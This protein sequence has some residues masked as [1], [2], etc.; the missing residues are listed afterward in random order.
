[1]IRNSTVPKW[2]R[3][4]GLG[5]DKKWTADDN[6]L[7]AKVASAIVYGDLSTA[8]LDALKMKLHAQ[9]IAP[10]VKHLNGVTTLYVVPVNYM[11]GFPV[12][13][14]TP[15]F[16]T[17][18]VPSGSFSARLKERTSPTGQRLLALGDPIYENSKL[19]TRGA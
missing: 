8:D 14:L 19:P 11:S 3:L 12:D 5:P 18:Y 7:P 15:G 9:R 17:S 1:M 13:S 2:E 6:D 4:P 16:V 10:L